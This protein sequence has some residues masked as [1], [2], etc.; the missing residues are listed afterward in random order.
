[1]HIPRLA[2][3]AAQVKSESVLAPLSSELSTVIASSAGSLAMSSSA[4]SV[5]HLAASSNSF[6]CQDSARDCGAWVSP[7]EVYVFLDWRRN[8]SIVFF[9]IDAELTP[10]ELSVPLTL[11]G[12]VNVK[13]EFGASA[14]ASSAECVLAEPTAVAA[15]EL[16][17]AAV[18]QLQHDVESSDFFLSRQLTGVGLLAFRG[19]STAAANFDGGIA[20]SAASS[21]SA[22][23][24]LSDFTEGPSLFASAFCV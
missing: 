6:A 10:P 2:L 18:D 8:C 21:T 19:S 7:C 14:P 16:A 13:A 23:V 1:M 4:A 9:H 15:D 5:N 12:S 22:G 17:K 3:T 20:A 11:T 24:S